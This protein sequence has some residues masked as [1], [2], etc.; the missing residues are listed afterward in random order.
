MPETLR[1]TEQ[2]LPVYMTIG[3]DD[4]Y[5]I[6]IDRIHE[7]QY[8]LDLM[9]TW[10]Y[11]KVL[12]GYTR[13]GVVAQLMEAC[14][15]HGHAR[16][17]EQQLGIIHPYAVQLAIYFISSLSKSASDPEC[18]VDRDGE[19]NLEWYGAKGHMLTLSIGA[20]G[21]ITYAYLH[22]DQHERGALRMEDRIPARLLDLIQR[23]G[24]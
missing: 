14:A 18:G 7:L 2:P 13:S 12:S 22:G 17:H 16:M 1:L 4:P 15:E 24:V 23:F 10:Q 19:I 5:R 6:T 20:S 8:T 3:A 21:R 11:S 9:R